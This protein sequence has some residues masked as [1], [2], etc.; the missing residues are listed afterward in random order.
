MQKL[1]IRSFKVL[2]AII[3][4]IIGFEIKAHAQGVS[5]KPFT[6]LFDINNPFELDLIFEFQAIPEGKKYGRI[7]GC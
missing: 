1:T 4:S 5:E 6:D 3:Y 7:H 2:I